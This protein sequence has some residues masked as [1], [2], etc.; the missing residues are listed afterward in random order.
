MALTGKELKEKHSERY[1]ELERQIKEKDAILDNYRSEHGKL[2]I[3]FNKVIDQL[4][5]VLPMPSMFGGMV[6]KPKSGSPIVAV[7]QI[8]DS[9]MGAIQEPGEIENFN[10]FNP[11]ICERRNIEYVTRFLD[12]VKMH[13]NSYILN[14][15]A[16]I[17][18]GDLISGSIHPELEITNAFPT[19][20]QV[21]RAAEVLTKQIA[22]IAPLF[23]QVTVHFLVEDNHA[24]LTKKP[25]MKEAGYNSL[26]YVVGKISQIYL[27]KHKNVEFNIYPQFEK[28]IH[29]SNR[30]YLIC[31]GHK[32][33]QNMGVPW[34]SI[35]RKVGKESSSRMQIIMED[36][37]RAKDVGFHKYVFGHWH[38]PFESTL[39]ACCGSISGTDAYDHSFGRFSKPSQTSWMVHP[40]HGE[41]N[42]INFYL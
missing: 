28:V 8:T 25:Q 12:W 40:K 24:R 7:M 30:Q 19:P 4:N 32:I 16:I 2:E 37:N 39:Y 29:V 6:K 36:L 23:K 20:L 41:F 9:H 42:R 18:T 13:R 38:T 26:N 1:Q 31:H 10:E 15:C 27:E 3:F 17:I 11:E 5:P 21:V 35:E 33:L 34:Y 14:D 22:L